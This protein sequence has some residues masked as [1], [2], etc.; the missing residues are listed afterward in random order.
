MVYIADLRGLRLGT[1]RTRS[2]LGTVPLLG[3][4]YSSKPYFSA[5]YGGNDVVLYFIDSRAVSLENVKGLLDLCRYGNQ[6]P[7]GNHVC[8]I[9]SDVML[10]DWSTAVPS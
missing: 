8:N 9:L 6:F 2:K 7:H 10:T 5:C 3:T 1:R 4:L